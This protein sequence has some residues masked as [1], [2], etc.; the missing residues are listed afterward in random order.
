M[1][2]RRIAREVSGETV[3][4]VLV[5]HV[6]DQ[7]AAAIQLH[8]VPVAR[9]R[10]RRKRRKQDA[11]LFCALCNQR[12][13]AR[14]ANALGKAHR[15]ALFNRKCLAIGNFDVARHVVHEACRP[16]ARHLA[17]HLLNKA[18]LHHHLVQRR[19]AVQ[20]EVTEL[21]RQ[22]PVLLPLDQVEARLDLQAVV[23]FSVGKR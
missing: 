20:G 9:K 1:I 2:E 23:A 18:R 3:R 8:V 17:T 15:H 7:V 14:H 22:V 10:R 21:L 16:R 11:I 5:V 6:A 4:R 12:A 13:V 19:V